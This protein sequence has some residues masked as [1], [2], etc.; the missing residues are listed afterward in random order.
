MRRREFLSL[1]G[2]A[3]AATPGAVRA[4]RIDKVRRI[5]I[6]MPFAQN[7]PEAQKRVA[8]FL[9]ELEQLGWT[10]GRNLQ[11]EYRW[12]T[13]DQNFSRIAA[14]EL[15]ALSPDA[16]LA[17]ATPAVAA[18]QQATR[19]V[20]IIFAMVADPVSAGF[21]ASLAKP[22]GNITGFTNIEYGIGSKWLE[23][24][25]E[26]A[27]HVKRVGVIRD[28]T[29]TA[30][31]GQIGAIQSVAP[32]YGVELTPL[33]GRNAKDVEDTITEFSRRLDC[34]L[35]SVAIPLTANHRGLIISLAA[36]HRL[37]ATYP[38]SFFV[39]DGGL[40]SYGPDSIDP[41]QRAAYYVDRIFR[42][43]KA[44]DL[45]VQVPTKYELAINLKTAKALGLTV[46]ITLL[47]RADKVIE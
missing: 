19:T 5:G 22:G 7:N 14:T 20:P 6:L 35:I 2:G 23:L 37:P 9:Q 13:G 25:K 38:F 47:T 8:T 31:I 11:I 12:S 41:Y 45:P 1:L 26:I 17:T 33:G 24:L 28:P 3:V 42:G 44:A 34:G 29:V 46:P 36:R 40:I 39:A 27:P 15:V 16:I 18:L 30:S 4:Q 10:V 32:S 21:V 43:E